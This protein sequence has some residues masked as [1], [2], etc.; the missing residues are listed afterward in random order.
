MQP[1][2][3]CAKIIKQSFGVFN[4][5]TS[6]FV[7]EIANLCVLV[8]KPNLLAVSNWGTTFYHPPNPMEHTPHSG[9]FQTKGYRLGI[10]YV[11][12]GHTWYP[13]DM[14]CSDVSKNGLC[15]KHASWMRRHIAYPFELGDS[16]SNKPAWREWSNW[17]QT[18]RFHQATWENSQE[19]ASAVKTVQAVLEEWDMSQHRLEKDSKISGYCKIG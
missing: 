9:I 16:L 4:Q 7:V 10:I 8:C 14:W 17:R 12:H 6:R 11:I 15:P 13:L 5:Q 2:F 3:F 1:D 18:M 19:N